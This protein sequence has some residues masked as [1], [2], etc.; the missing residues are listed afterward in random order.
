M[1][2]QRGLVDIMQIARFAGLT[3]YKIGLGRCIPSLALT[4]HVICKNIGCYFWLVIAA[5]LRF[6]HQERRSTARRILLPYAT[7]T[8]LMNSVFAIF[9]FIHEAT[10]GPIKNTFLSDS[11]TMP[12][13]PSGNFGLTK[14]I[15]MTLSIITNDALYVSPLLYFMMDGAIKV[16]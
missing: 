4:P 9:T 7:V 2:S 11:D 15:M 5:I 14:N 8:L 10:Q 6:R 1:V 12:I 16:L 3:M 13:S